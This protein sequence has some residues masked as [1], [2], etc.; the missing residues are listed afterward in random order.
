MR[1]G[2]AGQDVPD[3]SELL[4]LSEAANHHPERLSPDDCR[5]Q[6]D[7]PQSPVAAQILDRQDHL[8][9]RPGTSSS[10]ASGGERPE[11]SLDASPE[12]HWKLRQH[13][14]RPDTQDADAGR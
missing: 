11:P 4:L 1:R 6:V 10:D 14:D 9:D 13:P 12:L 5:T 8:P 3:G 7:P 2:H